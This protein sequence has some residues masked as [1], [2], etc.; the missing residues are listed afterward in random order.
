MPVVARARPRRY[1]QGIATATSRKTCTST[2]QVEDYTNNTLAFP[3]SGTKMIGVPMIVYYYTDGTEPGLHLRK[4]C[5]SPTG[6]F[7]D[8]VNGGGLAAN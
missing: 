6:L 3:A 7:V 1:D 2:G 5:P 4:R 8:G